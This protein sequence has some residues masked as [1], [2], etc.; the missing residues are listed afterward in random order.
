MTCFRG[1]VYKMNG[2]RS[3]DQHQQGGSSAADESQYCHTVTIQ[4]ANMQ[5]AGTQFIADN[6]STACCN[7]GAKA[8][9]KVAYDGSNSVGSGSIKSEMT[10]KSCVSGKTNAPEES[11]A[12]KRYNTLQEVQLQ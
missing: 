1:K 5:F 12:D 11:G 8:A 10:N 6:D 7:T 2:E 9:Y 4:L 3:A